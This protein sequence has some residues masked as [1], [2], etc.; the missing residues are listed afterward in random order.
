VFS[1]RRTSGLHVLDASGKVRRLTRARYDI[2][3]AWSPDGRRIAFLRREFIV[4]VDADGGGHWRKLTRLPSYLQGWEDWSLSPDFT[5]LLFG[6]DNGEVFLRD[7]RSGTTRKLRIS[8]AARPLWSPDGQRFVFFGPGPRNS[9]QL[10]LGNADGS[11]LRPIPKLRT[12]STANWSPDGN[13]LVFIRPTKDADKRSENEPK[14]ELWTAR[15]DGSEQ[16][17]VVPRGS[18][19][20]I[21]WTR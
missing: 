6:N 13:R 8:I 15:I 19:W 17:R 20:E 4:S 11:V 12:C 14:A 18:Q 7:L 16:R 9:C 21:T 1:G 5:R 3:F 2:G 10:H